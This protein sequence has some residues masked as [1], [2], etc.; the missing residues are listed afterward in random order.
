VFSSSSS[1]GSSRLVF[2]RD[3]HAHE[4]NPSVSSSVTVNK[5]LQEKEPRSLWG[6]KWLANLTDAI[7][8]SNSVIRSQTQP[9][10]VFT[11]Y[12]N[13]HRL[14]ADADQQLSKK[15]KQTPL[16][17]DSHIIGASFIKKQTNSQSKVS[18]QVQ[19]TL[20]HLI[21]TALPRVCVFWDIQ[22][23]A[24]SDFGC[25]IREN[26][27]SHTRENNVSHTQCS[28][29]QLAPMFAILAL[30]EDPALVG[31]GLDFGLIQ[32][33]EAHKD[34]TNTVITVE[35]ATYL[36]S[37]ICLLIIIILLI[38]FRHSIK[39]GL[40]KTP[41]C[42]HRIKTARQRDDDVI[43]KT[44]HQMYASTASITGNNGI[45][46]TLEQAPTTSGGSTSS[47]G[48]A[49]SGDG[50]PLA[51]SKVG[52]PNHPPSAANA[53]GQL[54][55]AFYLNNLRNPLPPPYVNNQLTS[56]STNQVAGGRYA[57]ANGVALNHQH[58]QSPPVPASL[59]ASVRATPTADFEL[60]P[61]T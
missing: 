43:D 37:S 8:I 54:N 36:V 16:I 32:K 35:I 47:T 40:Q 10:V 29:A 3:E 15:D 59:P 28:C 5:V 52:T 42:K 19:V 39:R 1:G 27:V 51:N 30:P 23:E 2:P 48:T 21:H 44:H 25:E 14:L 13:L 49:S 22:D 26:N 34:G 24:W 11:S 9:K 61:D 33:K 20:E 7:G 58:H 57:S 41:C 56:S 17:L 12:A 60:Y 31:N 55:N 45:Q 50:Q 38:Q 6:P 4:S 46:L 18:S 53:G